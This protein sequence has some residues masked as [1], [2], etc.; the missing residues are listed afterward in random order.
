MVNAAKVRTCVRVTQTPFPLVLLIRPRPYAESASD[1]SFTAVTHCPVNKIINARC[2]TAVPCVR[3]TT[4]SRATQRMRA[5]DSPRLRETRNRYSF[6]LHAF[7]FF[8]TRKA[9]SSP[10]L[11]IVAQDVGLREQCRSPKFGLPNNSNTKSSP[12]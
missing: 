2:Y 11:I 10:T 12:T 7:V 9:I 4:V 8:I 6:L 1:I 3:D 5:F